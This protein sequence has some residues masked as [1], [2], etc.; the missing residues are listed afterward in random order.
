MHQRIHQM[1][2]VRYFTE[3][4][5]HRPCLSSLMSRMPRKASFKNNLGTVKHP[6][7]I[8]EEDSTLPVKQAQEQRNGQKD[9][10]MTTTQWSL[11]QS[12]GVLLECI[13]GKREQIVTR[14]STN[15][16]DARNPSTALIVESKIWMIRQ[17]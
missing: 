10:T 12:F 2:L 9:Q 8:S 5:H 6:T 7:Y 15:A 13:A 4:K 17:A 11:C 14:Q 16:R 3:M 1:S